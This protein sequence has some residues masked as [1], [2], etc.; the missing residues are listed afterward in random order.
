MAVAGLV[1]DGTARWFRR[2]FG[3]L[4]GDVIGAAGIAAEVLAL[5]LL[6]ARLG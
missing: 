4:A 5:A 3:G 6:S 1:A 2:R